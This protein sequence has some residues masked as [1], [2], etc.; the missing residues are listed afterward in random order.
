MTKKKTANEEKAKL[1]K[2]E[3]E[4]LIIKLAKQGE[5]ATKIGQIL[6][7]TYGVKTVKSLK[8]KIKKFLKGKDIKENIPDDLQSLLKRADKLKQHFDK[9]KK[10]Q[11]AR[12]GILL[13]GAKIRKLGAYYKRKGILPADWKY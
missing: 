13:A 6:K 8:F 11:T 9:N 1:D 3:V 5:S 7:D 10:D 2:K 12:R 4:E